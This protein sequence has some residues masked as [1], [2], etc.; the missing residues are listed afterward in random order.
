MKKA[1]THS[2]L[3]NVLIEQLVKFLTI[4]YESAD[5]A[6]K[7]RGFI[8]DDLDTINVAYFGNEPDGDNQW[9]IKESGLE[10]T[11][12]M[13][14]SI[15][16]TRIENSCFV[17]EIEKSE[18]DETE[19][20]RESEFGTHKVEFEYKGEKV[21]FEIKPDAEDYWEYI[22]VKTEKSEYNFKVNYDVEYNHIAV[23]LEIDGETIH[24]QEITP[25][26]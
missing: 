7:E 21:S 22:D 14:F 17:F 6:E 2:E 1:L 19:R 16:T 13:A 3:N 9:S 11:F 10:L 26:K 8:N 24:H 18:T 15:L 23:Y 4:A 12:A 25:V 5:L 20:Q